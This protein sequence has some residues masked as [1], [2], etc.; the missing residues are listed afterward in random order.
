MDENETAV[1]DWLAARRDALLALI[2][3]LVDTDSGSHDKAGVDAAGAHLIRFL[4]EHG[5]AVSVLPNERF[6][7]AIRARVERPGSADNRQILLL[8]H[9]D[10]VFREG[11]AHRRPFRITNGRGSGPGCCDMKAGLAINAFVLAA[12]A[13][14]AAAPATVT[15]L[16]TADEE[17]G[18]PSSK[19]LIRD[20]ARAARAVFNGEPGRR[21]GGV[22]TGRKGGIFMRIA[23]A[24][25]AA[26]SGNAIA[27]GV[28]AI[29]EIARKIIKLHGS[30]TRLMAS[31]AMSAPSP[32]GRA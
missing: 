10:T 24:G 3:A 25:K 17:I 32:A 13:K 7:D 19:D 1:L 27:D 31:V 20:E 9:R 4:A 29:E 16:F 23:V 30:P 2:G 8:G 28:S 6:G 26:H 22:V 21:G 14:F 12:L 11:E 5:I 18:S 15:A